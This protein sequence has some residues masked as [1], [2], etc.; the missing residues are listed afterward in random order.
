MDLAGVNARELISQSAMPYCI[1]P[2]QN[3]VLK[4]RWNHFVQGGAWDGLGGAGW[5]GE[6]NVPV[7]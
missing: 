7:S 1:V 3:C 4:N 2:G 5:G 6:E